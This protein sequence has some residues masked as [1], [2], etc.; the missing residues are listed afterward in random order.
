MS[1]K[2]IG[3]GCTLFLITFLVGFIRID[4][5]TWLEWRATW[6]LGGGLAMG[7]G[8]GLVLM[9]LITGKRK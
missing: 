7:A 1:P 8:I 4:D 5:A 3:T 9:G 6:I 2:M